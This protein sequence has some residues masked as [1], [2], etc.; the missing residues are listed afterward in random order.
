[1]TL[2]NRWLVACGCS[3]GLAV[4]FGPVF[5]YCFGL[6]QKPIL[7]ELGWTRAQFSLGFS[8][9]TLVAAGCNGLAG[10]L[11]DRRHG[12]AVI[13]A[14]TCFLP[15]A[16]W[17]FS[18]V[19][20]HAA[21]LAVAAGM[22]LAGGT[23]SYPAYMPTLPPWF[24]AHLGLAL[25]I[26]AAGVGYG[27]AI[28]SP[29]ISHF[30]ATFGWRQ[31]LQTLALLVWLIG[32]GNALLFIR[33]NSAS[34]AGSAA[35]QSPE[36]PPEVAFSQASRSPLFWMLT[37]AFAFIPVVSI[38]VN[39]HFAALLTDRGYSA[40]EAAA[41]IAV[42]G[43][44]ILLARVFTGLVLDYV[45]AVWVGVVLFVGQAAGVVLLITTRGDV[46]PFVAAALLGLASGGEGDLMP[47][48][49]SRRFGQKAYGKLYG[50][51]FTFFN[52]GTL[53]GPLLMGWG[54]ERAG[55]Y[56]LTLLGFIP[57]SL[58]AAALIAASS[59]LQVMP[60]RAIST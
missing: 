42:G 46:T 20:S 9:A 15:A 29:L 11:I 13:I 37:A 26:A 32:M 27:T 16:L 23:T 47:Y 45:S 8:L 6:F 39:F 41:V 56:E 48:M 31:A 14:G 10:I 21:F 55:S 59:T 19:H 40:S 30:I 52:I 12:R 25:S 36:E 7:A 60:K 28:L 22:G 43:V 24:R 57:L 50:L 44:A 51:S 4:G 54:F 2:R 17:A 34:T 53:I 38:G 49:Y 1:M 33:T 5:V 58:C 18:Q 35:T 3:L